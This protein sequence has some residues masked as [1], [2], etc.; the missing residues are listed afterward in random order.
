MPI[1][2]PDARR[3]YNKAYQKQHYSKNKKYYKDKA[4]KSKTLQRQWNRSFVNR[5]KKLISCVDCGESNPIVLD[6]DHVCGVKT[7]NIA[8]MVHRPFSISAIK[9][10]IRKCE[11]RC[12]NCHRK[13]THKRRNMS[14]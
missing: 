3:A 9:D 4:K 2:D 5:V 6:F 1:K 11:V 7:K 10:E 13:Q 14:I 8:D 12:A